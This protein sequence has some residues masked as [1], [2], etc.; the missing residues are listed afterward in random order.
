MEVRQN[1]INKGQEFKLASFRIHGA[2]ATGNPLQKKVMTPQ[3]R[4]YRPVSDR[5]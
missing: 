5:D 4:H 2:E 1:T 3:N